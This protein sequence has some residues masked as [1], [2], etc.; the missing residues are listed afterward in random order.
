MENWKTAVYVDQVFG[1]LWYLAFCGFG[2]DRENM[3][4]AGRAGDKARNVVHWGLD[5]QVNMVGP[6]LIQ[7]IC[8]LF[9]HIEASGRMLC[10]GLG[11][12]QV[13]FEGQTGVEFSASLV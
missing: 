4:E 12:I 2:V 3:N 1:V 7:I 6:D 11:L 9:M 10:V 8:T 5:S 13:P